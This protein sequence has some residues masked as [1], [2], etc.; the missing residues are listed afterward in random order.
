MKFGSVPLSKIGTP[1]LG[2]CRSCQYFLTLYKLYVEARPSLELRGNRDSLTKNNRGACAL[3][4]SAASDHSILS[5]L[6]QSA[7]DLVWAC[8]SIL[9]LVQ[10][11]QLKIG[12]HLI[13][14]HCIKS[15]SLQDSIE[16]GRRSL[17]CLRNGGSYFTT[18][19]SVRRSL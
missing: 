2:F 12:T 5:D 15:Q 10:V 8:P 17:T 19:R 6:I 4:S 14:S 11:S 1:L 16:K 7:G 9:G 3:T 13:A 18:T